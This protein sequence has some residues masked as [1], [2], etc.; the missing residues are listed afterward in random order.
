MSWVVALLARWGV[1]E[2]LAGKLA[3]W[4]AGVALFA[5]L[6]ALWAAYDH[7]NDRQAIE[8][9]RLEADNTLLEAQIR[10]QDAAAAERL[11][12]ADTN[13]ETERAFDDA[14]LFPKS[15]DDPDP[16][17]RLAC[18]RLRRSGEDTSSLP[19]CGGR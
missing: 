7:F 6:A 4:V 5:I 19:G 13:S 1:K 10:T 14:I 11:R 15:D 2:G 16:A 12:N 18:E 3:P 17:V 8:R 9:D